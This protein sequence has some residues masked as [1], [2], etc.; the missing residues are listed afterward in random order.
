VDVKRSPVAGE[1]ADLVLVGSGGSVA[2]SEQLFADF[3]DGPRLSA[4]PLAARRRRGLG[5]AI[6]ILP[7]DSRYVS[8]EREP[9]SERRPDVIDE[10]RVER[11]LHRDLAALSRI[12]GCPRLYNGS[13][14]FHEARV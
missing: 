13:R 8:R 9:V 10:G 7:E 2:W 6:E 1:L 3:L 14:L 4:S 11:K 12:R 5:A